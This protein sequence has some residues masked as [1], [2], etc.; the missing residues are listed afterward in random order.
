MDTI[1]EGR[2]DDT[3]KMFV[4]PIKYD[5]RVTQ[6]NAEIEAVKIFNKLKDIFRF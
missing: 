6:K 5:Y 2:F 3:N 4:R 1:R